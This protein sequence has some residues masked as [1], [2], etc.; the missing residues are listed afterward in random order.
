MKKDKSGKSRACAFIRSH[1]ISVV[2][3]DVSE[4]VPP[5]VKN[6]LDSCP[7]CASL[8]Q[9]FSRAWEAPAPLADTQH[10][11][12]F[13]PRLIERIEAGDGLRP[14]RRGVLAIA[15]RVLKPAALATIFLGG[16]FAGH[17]LGKRDITIPP[18]EAPF[19]G[20]LLESFESIPP[21][22]VADF[23]VNRHQNSEKEGLE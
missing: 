15:W 19:A 17:E 8:V 21:G 13:F 7:E 2:E 1:L 20:Q 4:V 14:G 16:I 12:A 3:K 18:P 5:D 10:S 22:S 6:H 11:P 9:Q 23:Y